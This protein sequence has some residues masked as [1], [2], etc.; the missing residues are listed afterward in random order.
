MEVYSEDGPI[1]A[2]LRPAWQALTKTGAPALALA[3]FEGYLAGSAP[4]TD[5]QRDAGM[6][7]SMTQIR[8]RM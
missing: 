8:Q 2:A 1:P 7:M 6:R 4:M 5:A 3:Q